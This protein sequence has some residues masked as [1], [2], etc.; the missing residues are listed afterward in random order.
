MGEGN[1][2]AHQSVRCVIRS[3]ALSKKGKTDDQ[4]NDD[5]PDHERDLEDADR[6]VALWRMGHGSDSEV[7]R[8]SCA[9]LM[10]CQDIQKCGR[11]Y[12]VRS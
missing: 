4:K 8:P 3:R 2:T 12:L 1:K 11:T 6:A 9:R 5:D 7:L 10:S